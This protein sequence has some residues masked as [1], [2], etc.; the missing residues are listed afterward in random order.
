MDHFQW[1]Q[2]NLPEAWRPYSQLIYQII[3]LREGQRIMHEA[4]S[5]IAMEKVKKDAMTQSISQRQSVMALV[6]HKR[7]TSQVYGSRKSI[8][9]SQAAGVR[10]AG[11]DVAIKS[12]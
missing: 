11:A 8:V 3:M 5:V 10:P 1:K 6:Q 9:S 7:Q 4:F 2:L 12:K